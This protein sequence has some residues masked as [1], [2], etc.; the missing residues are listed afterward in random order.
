MCVI[1]TVCVGG[2]I[3]CYKNVNREDIGGICYSSSLRNS[4]TGIFVPVYR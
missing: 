1:P 4:N 3:V 2:G